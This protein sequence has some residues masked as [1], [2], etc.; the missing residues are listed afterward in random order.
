MQVTIFGAAGMVGK[1]LC[2]QAIALG[3]GV[4]AF[5]R[6]IEHWLDKEPTAG[7][8]IAIKG[9]MMDV[10]GI[11]KAI[12]GADAVII[13]LSGHMESGDKSRIIGCRNI[14]TAMQ[15]QQKSRLIIV[16]TDGVLE[17]AAGKY[18]FE[19]ADYPADRKEVSEQYA[20]V[21]ELLTTTQLRYTMVCVSEVLDAPESKAYH[22]CLD[23]LPDG[24]LP[25][26]QAGDL[27]RYILR[28]IPLEEH[29]Y[30]RVG[31]G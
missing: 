31:I 5:D 10:E 25:P 7:Q 23:S 1:R 24:G 22:T 8:F 15:A 2:E 27:S 19:D 9:Y 17:D 6:K 30:H 18:V 14:I 16:S 28:T 4:T 12:R 29:V 26:I 20:R 3:W 21:W 11:A 13:A